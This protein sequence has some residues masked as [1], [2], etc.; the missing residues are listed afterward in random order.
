L[1]L[2]TAVVGVGL[3]MSLITALGSTLGL[4]ST[5]GTLAMML[6]LAVGIDYVGLFVSGN[7]AE[8][9]EGREPLEAAGRVVGTAGSAGAFACRT[10]V[11]PSP[12]LSVVGIPLLAKKGMAAAGTVV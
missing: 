5:T 12:A 9:P 8:L 2:L 10:L 11:T 4:S 3:G 1:P 7:R 6:G